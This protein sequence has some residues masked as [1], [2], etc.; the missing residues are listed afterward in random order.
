MIDSFENSV[1]ILIKK[2]SMLYFKIGFFV[3]LKVYYK[4]EMFDWWN[5]S[6]IQEFFLKRTNQFFEFKD[7]YKFIKEIEIL[8]K[9]EGNMNFYIKCFKL[10]GVDNTL[11]YYGDINIKNN[12]LTIKEYGLVQDILIFMILEQMCLKVTFNE[13]EEHVYNKFINDEVKTLLG[14]KRKKFVIQNNK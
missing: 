11:L 2:G 4:N 7:I 10:S 14:K 8:V 3:W 12:V 5:V 13:L 9:K 1:V 6:D